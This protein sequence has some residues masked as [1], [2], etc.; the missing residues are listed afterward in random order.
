ML[1]PDDDVYLIL[2]ES[3]SEGC[4]EEEKPIH[5]KQCERFYDCEEHAECI[6][7][8]CVCLIGFMSKNFSFNSALVHLWFTPAELIFN[9]GKCIVV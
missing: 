3:V 5:K 1:N 8:E 4:W 7:G 9:N 6:D 2:G